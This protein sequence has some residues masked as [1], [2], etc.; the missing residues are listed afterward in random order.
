MAG[1]DWTVGDWVLGLGSAGDANLIDPASG[2]TRLRN[3]EWQHSLGLRRNLWTGTY[4]QANASLVPAD[5]YGF[6]VQTLLVGIDTRLIGKAPVPTPAPVA[7]PEPVPTPAPTPEPTPAPVQTPAPRRYALTGAIIN[8]L[9]VPA[10]AGVPF[11]LKVKKGKG[12]VNIGRTTLTD[13]VGGY[14]FED[15][16]PG[17]YQLVYRAAPD[18][19]TAAGAAVSVPV[20]VESDKDSMVNLDV[21]DVAGVNLSWD[22]DTIV[23]SWPGKLALPGVQYQLVLRQAGSAEDVLD[24]PFCTATKVRLKVSRQV[25]SLKGLM[26]SVKH[27]ER[28]GTLNGASR[29]GQTAF[30]PL[31]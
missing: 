29:Y 9:S 18:V 19:K 30:N 25:R 2:A 24:T 12:R 5:S 10:V 14:R 13:A 8:T 28:G 16:E 22:Q 15:L 23:A 4:L 6:P 31:P 3:H 27:V 7:D 21:W 1:L 26:Y 20:R 17:Q 11:G